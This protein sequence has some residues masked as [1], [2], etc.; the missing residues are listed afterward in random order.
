MSINSEDLYRMFAENA[1]DGM[2]IISS[3][4]FEFVNPAFEKLVGYTSEEMCNRR[5]DFLHLIHPDDQ[6]I[7]VE[8]KL[9]R[10]RGETPSPLYKF[11]VVTKKGEVRYVEVNT[12]SLPGPKE[13]VLGVCRDVT[14]HMEAERALA[15]SEEKYR[16]LVERANDGIA[17]IQDGLIKFIN[18]YL[19]RLSGYTPEEILNTPFRKY[20]ATD[21]FPLAAR[22]Y[23]QRME[24]EN[25]PSIYELTIKRKDGQKIVVEVNA[26][27]ILFQ[28][29]PADFI[30][31]RDISERKK[32]ETELHK[33]LEKLRRAMGATIQALNMAVERRDPY[34]AGH[35]R[36]VADLARTLATEMS[37]PRERIEGLR[38]AASIHDLG[39]ISIPTEIL[40]KP[41]EL[42]ETEMAW[43]KSHPR[44]GYEILKTIEFP[45]PIAEIVLQ[46]HEKMDGSGY[47]QGLQ[48][49][50]ILLEAR[51]LCVAD[52]IEA[53]VSHRPYR[54]AYTLDDSLLE[55]K[56]NKGVFYDC[57]VV[58]TCLRLFKKKKYTLR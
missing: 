58:E 8:R 19:V 42:N 37:L 44:I 5:F 17:L 57:D 4:G 53:M 48:G 46:H 21:D 2:Y 43:L 50:D 36:R 45:W 51:I 28:G 33:L 30:I 47:P 32:A 52:V 7:V 9:A 14:E 26:S 56:K 11:R 34:T 55:I 35:H 29:R 24:G 31:I 41:S 39:K 38:M 49:E 54:P 15:E 25:I 3:E 22:R 10:E 16:S 1:R 18:P 23:N 27:F 20:V 13:R 40:S 12:V 6:K